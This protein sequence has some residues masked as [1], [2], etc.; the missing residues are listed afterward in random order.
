MK[1]S[2]KE[3]GKYLGTYTARGQL[4]ENQSEGGQPERIR[5][6]D[7]RFDTA[8]KVREFWI[9]GSNTGTSSNIDASG[10]LATSPNVRNDTQF[11]N[12]DDGRELAWGSSAGSTDTVFNAPP[13]AIIDPEN[14]VIEDLFVFARAPNDDIPV[15]YLIVMDKFEITDTLGAVSMAKDRARDSESEWLDQ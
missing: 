11:F 5:L 4:T 8:F 3:V 13:G 10:K 2:R 12:A 9:W 6:F 14:L 15:N 7:G 1:N